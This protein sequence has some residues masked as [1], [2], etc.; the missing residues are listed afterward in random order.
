MTGLGALA[1]SLNPLGLK[2]ERFV[3]AVNDSSGAMLGFGQLQ[4]Y[5]KLDQPIFLE[6]RTLIVDP[7]C[8]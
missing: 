1:C 8:R 2:P 5:G 6:L 4:P 7:A 3:V